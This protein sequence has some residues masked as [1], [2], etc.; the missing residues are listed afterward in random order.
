MPLTGRNYILQLDADNLHHQT[1][2]WLSTTGL[3]SRETMFYQKLLDIFGPKFTDPANKVIIS[4]LQ[5]FITYYSSHLV[6]HY[7]SQLLDHESKLSNFYRERKEPDQQYLQ[8]HRA[9]MNDLRVQRSIPSIQ[10]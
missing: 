1:L 3:W 8:Q 5:N 2:E 6:T 7:R 4:N 10:E 9:L